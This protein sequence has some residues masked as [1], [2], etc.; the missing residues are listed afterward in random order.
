VQISE[1]EWTFAIEDSIHDSLLRV[2]MNSQESTE[3]VAA[4]KYSNPEI[5]KSTAKN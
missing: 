1:D 3:E 4:L 5:G 2:K